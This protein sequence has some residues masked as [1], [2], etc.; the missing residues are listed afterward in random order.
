M[1]FSACKSST[2]KESGFTLLE[3]MLAVFI[4]GLVVSM[5]TVSLS[6]SINAIDGTLQQGQLA[7]QAQVAMERISEDLSSAI[8]TSD[9]E[10]IGEQED[11]SGEQTVLLSFS[12]LAHL[13]FDPE[14][15]SPGMG[16][17]GYAVQADQNHE[18]DLLLLRSDV[19]QRPEKDSATGS[20]TGSMT[21][22]EAG[23]TTGS[24]TGSEA[25]SEVEAYILANRLRSVTFTYYDDEGEEQESWDTTVDKGDEETE[26]AKAE[27]RL[28]AAV[29]CRLEFWLDQD[30]HE[31]ERTLSFQTTVLL[32]T[33]LIQIEPEQ[34]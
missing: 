33:G 8:L 13:V 25:G 4:L 26:E 20:T 18:G 9:R 31:E 11:N 23:S 14:K 16:R 5:I 19:L 32:P 29:T 27:R 28:P 6:A 15:D 1:N 2:C 30:D 7:Y 34:E 17:I 10:F 3:I 22:S 12:S 21:G 24:M